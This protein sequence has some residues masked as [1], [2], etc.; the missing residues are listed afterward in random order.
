VPEETKE[1]HFRQQ[2]VA[3]DEDHQ[4]QRQPHNKDRHEGA[5]HV[6]F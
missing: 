1:S 2:G 4:S 3:N 5:E 6:N